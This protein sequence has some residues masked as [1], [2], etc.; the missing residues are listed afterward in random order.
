MAHR[1]S[2]SIQMLLI[3]I[4]FMKYSEILSSDIM[5]IFSDGSAH[6]RKLNI[7]GGRDVVSCNA[8]I[9]LTSRLPNLRVLDVSDCF[10]F[11][12]FGLM[13]L[14]KHC[15]LLEEFCFSRLYEL[16]S[17]DVLQWL[18]DLKHIKYLNSFPSFMTEL[19]DQFLV[20]VRFV[21]IYFTKYLLSG[22]CNNN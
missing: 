20:D 7:S 4:L 21:C 12:K 3:Q 13:A 15:P 19:F 17:A 10:K 1:V 18:A 2:R 16:L 14:A 5:L 22:M 9:A 8:I 6:L 11:D